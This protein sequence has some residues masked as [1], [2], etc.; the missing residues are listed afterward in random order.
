QYTVSGFVAGDSFSVISG[1]L[2]RLP[3]ENVGNYLY[4]SGTLTSVHNNYT[5]T[6]LPEYFIITPAPIHVVVN[7][8]Q[9]KMYGTSDP[10]S[11]SAALG[12]VH[13][14]SRCTAFT[15]VLQRSMGETV[16]IYAINQGTL[17]A[18]A[19]Y[20]LNSLTAADFEI[21]PALSANLQLNDATY[22]YD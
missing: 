4:H 17:Q 21:V 5:F 16:G 8:G 19:N 12:V 20:Q 18:N 9:H 11:N 14:D 7:P 1:L 10:F 6:V 22:V 3:G 15:G 2:G 13:G